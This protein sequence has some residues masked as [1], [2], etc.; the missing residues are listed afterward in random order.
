[1]AKDG[2]S[3][4]V[5]G[6]VTGR[7]A[8]GRLIATQAI[9]RNVTERRT[10][11]ERLHHVASHDAL[12]NLPNRAVFMDR[13]NQALVR[14]RR[15]TRPL[16]VLVLDLDRFKLINDTLGHASGD[17]L[18]LAVARRLTECLRDGDTVARFG[19]DEFAIIQPG[20]VEPNGGAEVARR[21]S[22]ALLTPFDLGGTEVTL[23]VSIGI[24]MAP[25]HGDRPDEL[26][27]KADLALYSA[28]E[29]KGT[30]LNFR[31]FE[32]GMEEALRSPGRRLAPLP[33]ASA[34]A[35]SLQ[36]ELATDLDPLDP[37]IGDDIG[38]GVGLGEGG[39]QEAASTDYIDRSFG[40]PH[41][42]AFLWVKTR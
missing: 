19:G 39:G 16:A 26:V 17:R 23:S 33:P 38:G 28:K 18:I 11:Q 14:V 8:D 30:G 13:L 10:W 32:P 1:V 4:L 29:S 7:Y 34:E 36:K 24:A 21:I 9:F 42:L 20:P 12:T 37:A 41:D 5:E 2:R 6:N 22:E 3:V 25:T 27:R 15:S 40:G 31:L 35:Q